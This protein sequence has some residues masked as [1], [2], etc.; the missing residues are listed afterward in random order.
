M[1]EI[2]S[3]YLAILCMH[4]DLEN[5]NIA[6]NSKGEYIAWIMNIV[7]VIMQLLFLST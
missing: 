5:G 1:N 6:E 4:A 7:I 2:K 3:L